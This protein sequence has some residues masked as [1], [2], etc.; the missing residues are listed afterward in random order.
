MLFAAFVAVEYFR[1]QPTNWR[2]TFINR[3]KIPY[4]T[5]VL[6]DQL[7]RLFPGQPISTIRV[8]IASQLLPGL[9]A[10]V[11][12]DSTLS[13]TGP[14][15]RA[16]KG[17]YLFVNDVFSCSRLDR[18]ALLRY[19]SQGNTALIAAERIDQ[20]LLDS[21]KLDV[22]PLLNMQELLAQR[23]TRG[24]SRPAVNSNPFRKATI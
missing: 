10:D 6:F 15:L 9:G 13:R 2:P 1:P 20:E 11:N 24:T 21:L 18:D 19:L 12:Q 22:Q 3:D 17:T 5:Y 4:G 16:D 14:S 7:P 8:P 23:R